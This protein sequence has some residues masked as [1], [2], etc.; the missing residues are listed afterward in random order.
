MR[1]CYYRALSRN[2]AAV[3][4]LPAASVG[5]VARTFELEP[6]ALTVVLVPRAR[7]SAKATTKITACAFPPAGRASADKTA[8]APSRASPRAR[9]AVT[10]AS[11]AR[12]APALGGTGRSPA[13]AWERADSSLKKRSQAKRLLPAPREAA[14]WSD[15]R[16]S[17]KRRRRV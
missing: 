14:R 1:H 2:S 13:A 15:P 3:F 6:A 12:R 17:S 10:P 8:V 4:P 16:A 9:S 5:C 11:S 7:S